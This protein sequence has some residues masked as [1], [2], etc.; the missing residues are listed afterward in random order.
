MVFCSTRF[1]K[2]ALFLALAVVFAAESGVNPVIGGDAGKPSA[3]RQEAVG[4]PLAAWLVEQAGREV[5]DGLKTRNLDRSFATFQ[6]YA[7]GYL[8]ATAG[9]A[10]TSEVTGNCRLKWYD[11]MMRD[12]LK[13]AVEAEQ[14]TREL[15]EALRRDHRGL[16]RA[17]ATGREKMDAGGR[18][19]RAYA[20]I[21]SPEQAMEVLK[22]ALADARAADKAA[23]APLSES[24]LAELTQGL[25]PTLTGQCVIGH[26]LGYSS[27]GRRLC[28][29]LEKMD[30]RALFDAAD[31][32]VPLSD[33][34]LLAQLAKIPEKGNVKARGVTGTVLQELVTPAGKIVIGG[35][36]RNVY[37]LD[38]MSDVCAVV[39]LGGNDTYGGTIMGLGFAWDCSVGML[40]D[41][42]GN[43]RYEATGGHTQGNGAQASLGILFD[44]GGN[45]TYLGYGQG[46]ASP[47]ISYHPLP[48]CG[49]NFS[50][51]I[52]YGGDDSYG[53]G[54]QNNSYNQRGSAGGF[55]VDRP[56]HDEVDAKTTSKLTTTSRPATRP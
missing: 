50:F 47:G 33:P 28:D 9:Q 4:N 17:L 12:P 1:P 43:D 26:A 56:L 29:L 46:W 23:K 25:Y 3:K 36:G 24:E 7:G 31:A 32:L 39:D 44:Y 30:R 14:F 51:V 37:Q 19:P 55:L 34:Q 22:K 27:A 54:V 11:R 20:A 48:S 21:T 18:S 40:F 49:G 15:H 16:D 38:E 52:D 8:D 53:C 2:S 13:A 6:S 45:D 41:F 10:W 5:K 35:R 42:G